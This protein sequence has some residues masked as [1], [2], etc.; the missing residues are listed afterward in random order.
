[1]VD[2]QDSK[3]CAKERGCSSPLQGIILNLNKFG[4]KSRNLGD[5]LYLMNG[6]SI[7]KSS[8]LYLPPSICF[9]KDHTRE[10]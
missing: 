6:E 4:S 9:N 2:T 7:L 10:D 5:T 8:I 3:S 1:M